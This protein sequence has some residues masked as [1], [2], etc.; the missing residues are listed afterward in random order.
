MIHVKYTFFCVCLDLARFHHDSTKA[1]N[2]RNVIGSTM[3][4]A[5]LEKST[6]RYRDKERLRSKE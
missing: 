5:F 1:K 6:A 2:V 4:A 3:C